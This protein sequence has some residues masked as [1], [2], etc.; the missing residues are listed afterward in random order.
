VVDAGRLDDVLDVIDHDPHVAHRKGMLFLP[1]LQG[2]LKILFVGIL[3]AQLAGDVVDFLRGPRAF[4]RQEAGVEVD[5]HHPAVLR[6]QLQHVVGHVTR[7]RRQGVG[8]RVREDHRGLAHPQGVLHGIRRNVRQIDQHAQPV[9]LGDHPFAEF[10]HALV[11]GFVGGGVGPVQGFGVR[12]RQVADAELIVG[13]QHAERIVDGVPALDADQRGDLAA[14]ANIQD[15]LDAISHLEI[16]RIGPDE[17][18]DHVDLL[19]CLL[20]GGAGL[21]RT[22]RDVGGPEL[23]ADA[24]LA[25][26]GNVGVQALLRPGDVNLL[27]RQVGLHAVLPGQV[28]VAV[29]QQGFLVDLE[30]GF[31]E[32]DGADG[33][34]VGRQRR[35]Q[36]NSQA[37]ADTE[38]SDGI[39]GMTS[40]YAVPST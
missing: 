29:D 14:F 30:R 23:R 9:H 31:G 13:P 36:E 20:D 34:V 32:F 17:A 15:V 21:A 4:R 22:H 10:G 1:L 24:A 35:L 5:H 38:Q 12:Q 37:K 27:E 16:V 19:Q 11:P 3:A 40:V 6:R 39:H 2:Q 25:Q 18:V 33:L 28:V 26:P 8:R 7:M